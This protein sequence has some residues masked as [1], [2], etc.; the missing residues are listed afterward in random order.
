MIMASSPTW[1]E[2]PGSCRAV[3]GQAVTKSVTP[4]G[5]EHP[6]GA[7]HS[8][9]RPKLRPPSA[10]RIEHQRKSFAVLQAAAGAVPQPVLIPFDGYVQG[11]RHFDGRSTLM[12]IQARVL[13]DTGHLVAMKDLEDLVRRFDEAM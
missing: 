6:V 7:E 10:R 5:V 13:R 11:V 2:E 4:G 1:R 12:D 3:W 9:E 8:L